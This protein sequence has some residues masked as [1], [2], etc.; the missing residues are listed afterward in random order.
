MCRTTDGFQIAEADLSI[1]GAGDFLGTRQ[2]G[3]NKYITLVMGYPEVYDSA[4]SIAREL[5][6]SPNSCALVKQVQ[7]ERDAALSGAGNAA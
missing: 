7:Q 4:R 6:A 3:E 5:L 1:R 2:S